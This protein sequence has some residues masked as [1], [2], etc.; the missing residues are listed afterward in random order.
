MNVVVRAYPGRTTPSCPGQAFFCQFQNRFSLAARY[1]RKPRNKIVDT[2]SVFQIFKQ[3]FYRDPSP[4]KNPSSADY[5]GMAF[6]FGA[7]IP[8]E[9]DSCLAERAAQNNPSTQAERF[10]KNLARFCDAVFR[11]D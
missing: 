1:S 11:A 5:I 2:G 10:L 4:L 6:D 7:L 8:I 9:H 3:C